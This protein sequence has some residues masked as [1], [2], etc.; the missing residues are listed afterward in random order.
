M[1]IQEAIKVLK[2][3]KQTYHAFSSANPD[4]NVN[5]LNAL[6]LAI[7]ILEKVCEEEIEKIIKSC[8]IDIGYHRYSDMKRKQIR[9]CCNVDIKDVASTI[10]KELMKGFDIKTQKDSIIKG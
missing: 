8:Q 3:I 5:E 4:G 10:V 9:N 6:S 1:T 2:E 7:S